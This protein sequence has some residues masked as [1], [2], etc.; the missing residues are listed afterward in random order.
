MCVCVCVCVMLLWLIEDN[1]DFPMLNIKF[2]KLCRYKHTVD[3]NRYRNMGR[4]Q[5]EASKIFA[6]KFR[7][8]FLK[9]MY[10]VCGNGNVLHGKILKSL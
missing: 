3:I 10:F 1:N 4:H 7:L 6:T 8:A 9:M 2:Y 5:V